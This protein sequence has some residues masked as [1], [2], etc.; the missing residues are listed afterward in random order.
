M[1]TASDVLEEPM[2]LTD[3]V[4]PQSQ[5]DQVVYV[6]TTDQE[7]ATDAGLLPVDAH[8]LTTLLQDFSTLRPGVWGDGSSHSANTILRK[9]YSAD[10]WEAYFSNFFENNAFTKNLR[11]YI[12]YPVFLWFG[13]EMQALQEGLVTP[14]LD[15]VERSWNS[16]TAAGSRSFVDNAT[17]TEE[18]NGALI[19][20]SNM[21][22]D[23]WGIISPET[24][25]RIYTTLVELY[26]NHSSILRHGTT[27]DP[28]SMPWFAT[29]RARTT[30][31]VASAIP[32]T[33]ANRLTA[34]AVDKQKFAVDVGLTG[35]QLSLWQDHDLLYLDN[36]LSSELQYSVVDSFLTQ[37]PK[38]LQNLMMISVNDFLGNTS[39]LQGRSI[40]LS[41]LFGGV[42][43]F[44]TGVGV[45]SE[46]SFPSG[47]T[48]HR[49][50]LFGL[51][52]GHE[53]S[54]N[55][56]SFYI[57]NSTDLTSKRDG[58]IQSAGT[59]SQNYLRS[60]VGGEF[61]QNAP[62]EFFASIG[63]QWFSDTSLTFDLALA[64]A[65]Q[66]LF[67]PLNQ[68]LF[69][70]DV[71]S[72]GGSETIFYQLDANG[73]LSSYT[74]PLSRNGNGSGALDGITVNGRQFVFGLDAEDKIWS[75]TEVVP[76]LSVEDASALTTLLQDF[77]TWGSGE[78]EAGAS[79][80]ANTILRKPYSANDWEAY[81]SNFFENNALNRNLH[82]YI[83]YPVFLW[84][85]S[86]MQE[87]QEGLVT[88]LL[89]IVER[90]WN[91]ATAAGNMA[92]SEN[93]T[94]ADELDSALNVLANMSKD[95]RGLISLETQA[96][97]YTRLAGLY[98]VHSS[99]L[100][101][102]STLDPA[103][104][105]WFAT[106]RARTT[107]V[108]ASAI[109]TTTTNRLTASAT[110]KQNFALDVG[111]SGSQL[112]L[113]QDHDV[114][115]LDNKLSSESRYSVVDSFLTQIP[116]ELQNLMMISVNDF[117][118]NTSALQ[119]REVGFGNVFG[120]VNNI[121][122]GGI[123]N[124]FPDD[125][126]TFSSS[127]FGSHLGRM[128]THNINDF[129]ITNENSGSQELKSR[130]S[131]LIDFAGLNSSNYLQS[132]Y[133]PQHIQNNPQ[134]FLA[135]TSGVWFSN[136]SLALDLGL[137]RA[138]QGFFGPLNQ[139]LFFADI[140]SLGS[141]ETIFYE[142]G[143]NGQLS[144]YAVPVSRS[145]S[146][147]ID[148]I[149][150]NGRQ[151]GFNLD[152]SKN[153]ISFYEIGANHRPVLD[154]TPSLEMNWVSALD[155]DLS[156]RSTSVASLINSGGPLN[157]FFD[158]DGDSPSIV[159]TEMNLQGGTLYWSYDNSTWYNDYDLVGNAFPVLAPDMF[160]AFDPS[161][162][163]SGRIPELFT[164]KACDQTFAAN[165]LSEATDTVSMLVRGDL[166]VLD[167]SASPRMN[168][169]YENANL[170]VGP[171]GTLVSDLIDQN[172]PLYN[173]TPSY[174]AVSSFD[175][176]FS[177]YDTYGI[178]I[179]NTD[180]QGGTLYVSP[181]DGATWHDTSIFQNPY[182]NNFSG[183]TDFY[184]I[185]YRLAFVSAADFHGHISSLLTIKASEV[186]HA[187]LGIAHP[188]IGYQPPIPNS[189]LDPPIFDPPIFDPPIFY[190]SP[191]TYNLPYYWLDSS[192]EVDSVGIT[193]IPVNRRPVLTPSVTSQLSPVAE[194]AAVPVG[195]VGTLVSSLI[196]SS[197]VLNNFSDA[198]GD[199]PGIAIV[200]A[201]LQGGA[202]Y[203]SINNGTTWSD[204][205]TVSPTS[206]RLFY[207]DDST[208]LYFKPA[209][210][211]NGSISD[212]VT[213]KAWDRTGGF[214]NGDA[215]VDTSII[216]WQESDVEPSYSYAEG[217]ALSEDNNY[218]Y[219]TDN[220]GLSVVDISDRSNPRVVNSLQTNGQAKNVVLSQDGNY[221]FIADHSNGVS[222][223]DISNPMSLKEVANVP[224]ASGSVRDIGVFEGE[225]VV[226]AICNTGKL[227]II[228]VVDPTGPSVVKTIDLNATAFGL[229]ISG[230][231]LNIAHGNKGLTTFQISDPFD[232]VV[233]A[234]TDLYGLEAISPYVQG[235]ASTNNGQ[236]LYTATNH[237]STFKM[238]DD[239]PTVINPEIVSTTWLAHLA[240]PPAA[241]SITLSDNEDLLIVSAGRGGVCIY[242]VSIPSRPAFL[243]FLELSGPVFDV[244]IS[245]DDTFLVT[246]TGSSFLDLVNIADTAAPYEV[247]NIKTS[248][249]FAKQR[250]VTR[251]GR[252]EFRAWD[253]K[254]EVYDLQGTRKRVHSHEFAWPLPWRARN[255]ILS[256]DDRFAF[257]RSRGNGVEVIDITDP[258]AL[259]TVAQINSTLWSND[260]NLSS[261]GSSII[262]LPDRGWGVGTTFYFSENTAFSSDTVHIK[263]L[264]TP[265][266]DR[267]TLDPTASPV[268]F[269][270][271]T[272]A[273]Q[274]VGKVGMLVSKFI[275][276]AGALDNFSDV[277]SDLPGIAMIGT[278]LG[279]GILWFST[280]EG[281]NW[282]Q[283]SQ[284]SGQA[285]TLLAAD[286]K[287][288]IFLQL[289]PDAE[290]RPDA[291][292]TFKAW[293]RNGYP[294]GAQGV[295]TS[296]ESY[297]SEQQDD[298]TL[299]KP[300]NIL[301]D[302]SG[303]LTVVRVA[304][305][306]FI[307]SDPDGSHFLIHDEWTRLT[308]SPEV[309]VPP[310]HGDATIFGR[311]SHDDQYWVTW[312]Y[313]ASPYFSGSD[314]FVIRL[315]DEVG[316]HTDQVISVTGEPGPLN[317]YPPTVDDLGPIGKTPDNPHPIFIG[318]NSQLTLTGI[319]YGN[320]LQPQDIRV[321]AV[322]D[323]GD[324]VAEVQYTS[325]EA[326]ALL[327]FSLSQSPPERNAVF[328]SAI[329]ITIEDAG[330]DNNFLT[331]GDNAK[332]EFLYHVWW[333]HMPLHFMQDG[334]DLTFSNDWGVLVNGI[335]VS[336]ITSNH[337]P[338]ILSATGIGDF[339]PV[340]AISDG[341]DNYL[342]L[343][344]GQTLNRLAASSEWQ[345]TNLFDSLR[346]ESSEILDVSGRA[347]SQTVIFAAGIG[348][349]EING[350]NTPTL[351]VRRNQ[352]VTFNLN[353]Q[354]MPLYVQ[355]TST[356]YQASEMYSAFDANGQ[357]SGQ[358][359]WVIPEDAPDE[360]F[361]TMEFQP[362][363]LG[364][365]IV[366]D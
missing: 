187:S 221:A 69:T 216:T 173:Y 270:Q 129:Y 125:Y 133:T 10:G 167:A 326:R 65:D 317:N 168:A 159:I 58:L 154:P 201:S 156:S 328:Q 163:F 68:F 243:S 86:E 262:I 146:G 121:N 66:G 199:L 342:L 64:R 43:T 281:D 11:D 181:D 127:R 185:D 114:L 286:N 189:P 108:L 323:N 269:T 14:L 24:Q 184:P 203:Y 26:S 276:D 255:V 77:S 241:W 214:N 274:P 217:V 111:L 341:G 73:Q 32:T 75:Y 89:D 4:V 92:F 349:Y 96:R 257:V 179:T 194:D 293:D 18:L 50:D 227:M 44:S 206:A 339:R 3:T 353:A 265:V 253:T 143:T 176:Y 316:G 312:F 191:P 296:T 80:S 7:S 314:S 319:S 306:Q 19:M 150:V 134:Q 174:N 61:F 81:F 284:V 37:I 132:E 169:A 225:D 362:E 242:D 226:Y 334:V 235:I 36:K 211:F 233:V 263:V 252:Y 232:P 363:G 131:D 162:G 304:R 212:V 35:S 62:Q 309:I 91:S 190:P 329:T 311:W 285:A 82:N 49:S 303:V 230:D 223:I 215:G 348:A 320:D 153:V 72:R 222:I 301:G 219:V 261:D 138:A 165:R 106:L 15:I 260:I 46:N 333:I 350:V 152:A 205:G 292:V 94:L 122:D 360:L 104:M 28:V 102:S 345:V 47:H 53:I 302:L 244:A 259:V 105:P 27:H 149:T 327:D 171:V 139:F 208:R 120:A 298:I 88:P 22:K 287:T 8:A 155:T 42:N 25:A 84:F 119:G 325:P 310:E 254:L 182:D 321:S 268:L 180:L 183:I 200:G 210:D 277:D 332:T 355:T 344:R 13:S 30:L 51:A 307:W 196:D 123:R 40:G 99:V 193:V 34:S 57:G 330:I 288:R 83:N 351:F 264:V 324:I 16:A 161:T 2:F 33:T 135:S 305:G 136:T 118:G 90:S 177:H 38:D 45:V 164:V 338:Q 290:S 340:E 315:K 282:T 147:A 20:L 231:Y 245:D 271:A 148:G 110:D 337:L 140:F 160:L 218:A 364:K 248:T 251:D 178:Q 267:P 95:G 361:Y 116:K 220:I 126:R 249:S 172:G 280:D 128:I 234:P 224:A 103:S 157:N 213:C 358:Y 48:P 186:F 166:P 356:G 70:A 279:G 283:V 318:D 55:I 192:T 9:P 229:D 21:S 237:L 117:L 202:L 366:V 144:S 198:D 41:H 347:V 228:E 238:F 137:S 87:L 56:D 266:N 175:N 170:P 258:L 295:D 67:E 299:D 300:A 5:N 107:Q 197:G 289:G 207:A 98:S 322:S 100:R 291:V 17:L 195:A 151:F 204:V 336:M 158:A 52:L 313:D 6:S 239:D 54:H 346:N 113:W 97:I 294:N 331:S 275:D 78:W 335:P 85:G 63:N 71:Y 365:I 130:R 76:G 209:P 74:V 60:M 273:D 115:Y 145:S 141:D 12:G 39:A 79:H 359:E 31:T 59:N 93:V 240:G 297:F 29:L 236:Y 256:R 112:S 250:R 124:W 23:G 352:T 308:G 246:A 109:P 278:N 101:H 357:S 1:L 354:G 272:G 343:H 247:G 188:D 142:L